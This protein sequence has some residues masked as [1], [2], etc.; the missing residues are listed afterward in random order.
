MQPFSRFSGASAPATPRHLVVRAPNWVGDLCMATPVLE[1]ALASPRFERV[2]IAVRA[3]LAGVLENGPCER[4]LVR[5]GSA[6]AEL[7]QL[8][9]LRADAALLLSNS[10]G[11]AWRA[12]RA[13]IPLRAGAA[14]RG[15]SPLLTHRVVPPARGTARM[16]IPSAH[17][18]RDVAGLFGIL[19]PDLR[20]RLY[21]SAGDRARARAM[22]ARGGL[23]EGKPYVLCAPS[24]AFGA[25]KLW[26]PR[27]FAVALDELCA[28]RGLRAVLT[29]GPG[30]EEQIEAVRALCTHPAI[31]LAGEARDLSV[32]K[33]LV[34]DAALVLVGDSGPRWYAAAFSVPCVTVMGP[35]HPLLTASSLEWCEIVRLDLEC[36][37]CMQR[38]CPLGHHRCMED[39]EP[40]L[41]LD[42]ARRLLN[43]RALRSASD[44]RAAPVGGGGGG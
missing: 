34:E 23:A 44:D 17:L 12:F 39:L 8:R 36:S 32:L 33:A 5:L 15:R 26:P 11:A 22:L 2:T 18:M 27:H 20:P 3:P 4:H 25:A 35:N 30:E 16:P 38:T 40:A 24:A 29:G 19:V 31:S 14:M 41:V 1:A 37:P 7:A 21:P 9:E 43:R 42:A 28:T 13:R 6:K 10:L